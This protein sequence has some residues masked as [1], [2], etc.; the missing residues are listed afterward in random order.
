V[1]NR[2]LHDSDFIFAEQCLAGEA[3]ALRELR[4]G[5]V[6][7]AERFLM[8]SG[9]PRADAREVVAELMSELVAGDAKH[10]PLLA[11]Y[12]GQCSLETWLNRAAL[13]RALTR[14]RR[15]ERYRKRIE[16][17]QA[18]GAL[19]AFQ[20][21][22]PPYADDLLRQILRDSIQQ[23]LA[24]CP[25]DDY[26]IIH[27]LFGSKLHATEVARMFQCN[28]RTLRARAEEACSHVRFAVQARQP[29]RFD[30]VQTRP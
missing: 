25:G 8:A 1:P 28:W 26:V 24:N 22:D 15:D 3:A 29:F 18:E 12:Q 2:S 30:V 19:G 11:G 10:Q 21:E 4:D 9:V 6:R 7:A 27:L 16:T 23:A 13:S 20:A 5:R 14:R 17:A